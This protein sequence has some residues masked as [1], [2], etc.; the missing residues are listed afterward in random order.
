MTKRS[1]SKHVQANAAKDAAW[2]RRHFGELVAKHPGKY[3]VVA[4]GEVFVGD[5][6][7]DLHASARRAHP[8]VIPTSFPIPRPED[9]TCAL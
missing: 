7:R 9:F 8:N 4:A 6:P 3:A 1:A 2:I 5:D